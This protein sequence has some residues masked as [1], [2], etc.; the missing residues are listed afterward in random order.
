[1]ARF[2]GKVG[3]GIPTD[4]G[5]GVWT[6]VITERDY[7]G[8]VLQNFRKYSEPD[9]KAN[10]DLTVSNKIS[11]VADRYAVQHFHYIKSL[12]W[13]GALWTVNT[14]EVNAPR[15]ILWLGRVYNGAK[16]T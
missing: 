8:D 16:A 7:T 14:V 13:E 11:I 4:A 5:N 9:E 3:F 6:D 1:M 2:H 12:S 15:L 10:P